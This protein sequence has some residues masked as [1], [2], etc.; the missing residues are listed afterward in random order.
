MAITCS[1][2][3]PLGTCFSKYDEEKKHPITIYGGGN[4]LAVFCDKNRNLVNFIMDKQHF[5]NCEY[6][7]NEFVDVVI[8]RTRKKESKQLINLL[9]SAN[10][11]FTVKNENLQ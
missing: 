8:Y 4:V 9:V 1:W 3:N 6:T 2:E 10:F 5:K 11:E 7:G